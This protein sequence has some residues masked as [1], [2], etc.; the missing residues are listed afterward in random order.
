LGDG[1]WE[2]GDGRWEMGDG[3]WEMGDGKITRDLIENTFL[4]EDL[5]FVKNSNPLNFIP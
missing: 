2:M 3:R 4:L 1:R 5:T